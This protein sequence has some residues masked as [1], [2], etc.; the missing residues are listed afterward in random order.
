MEP[1]NAAGYVLKSNMHVVAGNRYL[2]E[3]VEWQIKKK[4]VKKQSNC[5]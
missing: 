1:D 5:T 2:S 4:G 3:N